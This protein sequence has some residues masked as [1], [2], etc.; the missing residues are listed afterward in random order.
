MRYTEA[1]LSPLAEEML[2]DIESETVDWS[3]NFDGT[4]HEPRV[5]PS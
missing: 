1:R 4:L 5:V 3:D 2:Q